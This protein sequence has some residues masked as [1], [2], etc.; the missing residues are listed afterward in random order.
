[1]LRVSSLHITSV[2]QQGRGFHLGYRSG[3]L[4]QHVGLQC[5]W[6]KRSEMAAK[7]KKKIV[8]HSALVKCHL[9]VSVNY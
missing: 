6:Q 2:A 9:Q 3:R 8:Q 4:L 7:R 1:M 5:G